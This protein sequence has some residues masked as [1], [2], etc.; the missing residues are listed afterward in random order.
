LCEEQDVRGYPT[1]KYWADGKEHK[2]EGG[3]SLEQ[4]TAF[5]SE[6]LTAKCTFD[7]AENC[8]EKAKKYIVKWSEK[9]VEDKKKEIERLEKMGT[10]SMKADLKKW[11]KERQNILKS[12]IA[13]ADGE[14]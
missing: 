8:S 9:S 12:G 1:I 6:E 3:R 4:L 10:G 5:V 2:Y 13:G 14:L 7:D 11:I